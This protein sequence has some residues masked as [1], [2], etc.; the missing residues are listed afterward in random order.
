MLELKNIYHAH[1]IKYTDFLNSCRG[2]LVE[3]FLT[4]NP[5]YLEDSSVINYE[6]TK[7][8][9]QRN[10]YDANMI[11]S[12]TGWNALG[13]KNMETQYVNEELRERYPTAFKILDYFGDEIKSASYSSME[14]QMILRRHTGHENKEALRVRVHIPLIIPKGDIG[15]ECHGKAVHWDDVF[16]FNN[17]KS[18]SAWNFTD[19]RRLVF[20]IDLLRSNCDMPPAAVWFPGCNDD[21]PRFEKTER[22]SDEWKK[23]YKGN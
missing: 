10:A 13:F 21:A 5:A 11:T 4:Q 1:E 17:Q 22:E 16:A 8:L 23:R 18:H 2:G 12:P 3:D 7:H 14:P 9:E 6:Y 19:S 15:F 20:I